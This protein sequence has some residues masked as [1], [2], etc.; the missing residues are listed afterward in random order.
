M[1]SI[2][3]KQKSLTLNFSTPPEKWQRFL[4]SLTFTAILLFLLNIRVPM[5]EIE[6]LEAQLAQQVTH[7]LH[8][9]EDI[10]NDGF[11]ERVLVQKDNIANRLTITTYD[12]KGLIIE[13]FSILKHQW[14]EQSI[15]AFHDINTD[16]SKEL[17]IITLKNDSVYLNAINLITGDFIIKDFVI[18][19]V[20][21]PVEQMGFRANFYS[22]KDYN[23]DGQMEIY[24]QVDACY[25]LYPRGLY[26][27]DIDS[28]TL[29]HTPKSYIPWDLPQFSDINGDGVME[30]LPFNYSPCNVGFETS[31]SDNNPWIAVFDLYLNYLFKPLPMPEG[32]GN[33]S[34]SPATFSDTLFFALYCNTSTSEGKDEVMLLDYKGNVLKKVR[35]F[36]EDPVLYS[37]KLDIIDNTNYLIIDNIGKFKLNQD[38]EGLPHT[39]VKRQ[40]NYNPLSHEKHWRIDVDDD[41]TEESLYYN[42]NQSAI[43]IF[44]PHNNELTSLHLPFKVFSV[45]NIYPVKIDGTTDRLMVSTDSGYFFLRYRTNPLYWMKYLIPFIIFI[46]GYGFIFLIQ[47]LQRKRMEQKWKNDNQLTELQYNIIKNQLNPHF[48]FNTLNSVGYMIENSRKDEAYHFLTLNARLIRK[49]LVDADITTRSLKDEID[50]TKDYL[51]VQK[52][53]FKNRFDFIFE[54]GSQVNLNLPVP[55]MVIHTYAEN[56]VKHG[57]S[58]ISEGGLLQVGVLS[59]HHGV[60]IVISDNGPGNLQE[61][62]SPEN[63]G[64]GLD[65]MNRYYQLYEKLN[66]CKI[67]IIYTKNNPG[68]V[69]DHGTE[70]TITIQYQDKVV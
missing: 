37:K 58:G 22:M 18:G 55:K 69:S 28:L 56:A 63:T 35:I 36:N 15:P 51:S 6:F 32:Y 65:I 30:I 20:E 57:F 46:A 60:K 64:R 33:V 7:A 66:H 42:P 17:L 10:N 8:F 54:I 2:S 59:L 41:G 40:K 38:L 14:P 13:S 62:V 47:N 52:F 23:H 67:D 4:F 19:G 16:N 44:N 61:A 21:N 12:T 53:R 24:F 11:S 43:R 31:F 34:L 5:Y 9:S 27:L 48:I 3:A 25:G 39:N 45:L 1:D 26:R 68:K 29:W 50:F 49:V 70:V